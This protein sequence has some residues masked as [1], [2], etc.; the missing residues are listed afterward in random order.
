MLDKKE[1]EIIKRKFEKLISEGKI[2]KPKLGKKEFFKNK[3]ELSLQLSK[4]LLKKEEYLDWVINT[5][6]YSMFYNA[7]SLLAKISVDLEDIQES[8]HVLVYQ[9]LIYFFYIKEKRIE[10]EYLEE[11]KEN[12]EESNKR[13]RNVARQKSEEVISN[14]KNARKERAKYTYELGE[15]AKLASAQTAIRRANAFDI[16]ANK[17]L[18]N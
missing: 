5:A 12:M 17:L 18:L 16:I 14:F 7:I 4:D 11:F 13:L 6:Y 9:A 1:L 3:A 15:L 8:T 10:T 2:R